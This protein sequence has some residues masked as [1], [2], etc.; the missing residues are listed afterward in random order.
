MNIV[1]F[2]TNICI[3]FHKKT[4]S[5]IIF[6]KIAKIIGFIAEIVVIRCWFLH[7]QKRVFL[8]TG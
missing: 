1:K 7:F 2:G 3:I 8:I 6:H 4:N 5:N